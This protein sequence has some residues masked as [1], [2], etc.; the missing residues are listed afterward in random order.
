MTPHIDDVAL[1]PRQGG[2]TGGSIN[3]VR[4]ESAGQLAKT[5][6]QQV[7]K[8]QALVEFSLVRSNTGTIRIRPDPDAVEL[9]DLLPERHGFHERG[10][11]LPAG[12]R[13]VLPWPG[14]LQ[15][16]LCCK[17]HAAPFLEKVSYQ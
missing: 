6:H 3:R 7:F 11:P 4:A 10:D 1:Q 12:Q 13:D 14:D 15:G 17:R 5:V 2:G 8:V 16:R 9:R